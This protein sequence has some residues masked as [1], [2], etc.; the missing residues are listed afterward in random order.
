MTKE[1]LSFL[2]KIDKIPMTFWLVLPWLITVVVVL[3]PIGLPVTIVDEISDTYE[4]IEAIPEDGIVLVMTDWNL[5]TLVGWG[6]PETA[7]AK[8]LF[9][10]GLKMIWVSSG[11][12]E[13]PIALEQFFEFW[14]V[15]TD[16]GYEYG[17]DVIVTSY[18]PGQ[19]AAF[20]MVSEDIHSAV[21][22]DW[23]GTPLNELPLWAEVKNGGDFAFLWNAATGGESA[24]WAVR[25]FYIPW[26]IPIIRSSSAAD[27][28]VF[29]SY[30]NAG[31]MKG[32]V[33]LEAIGAAQYEILTGTPGLGATYSDSITV[34]SVALVLVIITGNVVGFYKDK[35]TRREFLK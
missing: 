9:D 25:Q 21:S 1:K 12:G 19:E 27:I 31:Q 3:N 17:K 30:Y 5:G 10:R 33:A 6:P 22:E 35:T 4:A 23:R 34:M 32:Y 11:S 2:E 7:I 14:G 18:I 13:T 29:I 28:P 20:S 8:H 24:H 16:Y 15:F 26:E